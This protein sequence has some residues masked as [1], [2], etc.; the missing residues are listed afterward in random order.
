MSLKLSNKI[1]IISDDLLNYRFFPNL[2]YFS[3]KLSLF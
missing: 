3:Y 2:I 1:I